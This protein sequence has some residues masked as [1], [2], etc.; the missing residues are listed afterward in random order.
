MSGFLSSGYKASPSNVTHL[1]L[2][3]ELLWAHSSV[4]RSRSSLPRTEGCR[5]AAGRAGASDVG[6]S[7]YS[8]SA[9]KEE[10]EEDMQPPLGSCSAATSGY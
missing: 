3:V 9:G 2:F 10:R 4:I 7:L 5:R 1:D 8:Y 6:V